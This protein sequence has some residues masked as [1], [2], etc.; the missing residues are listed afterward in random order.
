MQILFPKHN[1]SQ[2]AN[3]HTIIIF[4]FI[5]WIN[6]FWIFNQSILYYLLFSQQTQYF[7]CSGVHATQPRKQISKQINILLWLST[8]RCVHHGGGWSIR[9]AAECKC[10]SWY[11]NVERNADNKIMKATKKKR[12]P[13]LIIISCQGVSHFQVGWLCKAIVSRT[14]TSYIDGIT[15]AQRYNGFGLIE[16][17]WEK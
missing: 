10:K 1:H 9:S 7:L 3:Y 8:R 5:N 12:L 2:P 4:F 13:E 17:D 11:T 6:Y 15:C 14:F 16:L